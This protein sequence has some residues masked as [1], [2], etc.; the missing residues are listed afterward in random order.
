MALHCIAIVG[1]F[2]VEFDDAAQSVSVWNFETK[3]WSTY[4][5]KE[6]RSARAAVAIDEKIYVFG[7]GSSA[8]LS[9]SI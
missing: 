1:G 4:E 5:M 2:D 8:R 6:A 7:G 3:E 9:S